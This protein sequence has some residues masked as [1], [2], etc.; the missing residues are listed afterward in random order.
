MAFLSEEWCQLHGTLAAHL[1]ERPGVTASVQHVVTGGPDGDTRYRQTVVDGRLADTS[2][3]DDPTVDLIV[4]ETYADAR[5]I[6]RGELDASVA[7]MQGRVKVVG[8]MGAMLDLMPL[9]RSEELAAVRSQ[10][11][12]RTDW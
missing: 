9:L 4:T 1:P 10:V 12:A 7:Y 11:A 6:A 5:S 3:G 2:L 8:H